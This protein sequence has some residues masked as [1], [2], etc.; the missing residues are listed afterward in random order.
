MHNFLF[1]KV[2]SFIPLV[3]FVIIFQNN[4]IC[5]AQPSPW[6]DLKNFKTV[7]NSIQ[8]KMFKSSQGQVSS[9]LGPDNIPYVNVGGM[10]EA[11][12]QNWNGNDSN[13]VNYKKESYFFDGQD[14][15][16]KVTIWLFNDTTG[17]FEKIWETEMEYSQKGKI[18]KI[19]DK[20]FFNGQWVMYSY[21]TV[22]YNTNDKP[23]SF[24]ET[25]WDST[26][27]R[28]NAEPSTTG[29]YTYDSTGKV[30]KLETE[31]KSNQTTY[32][33]LVLLS[34]FSDGRLNVETMHI[35]SKEFRIRHLYPDSNQEVT[36]TYTD[37]T[38]IFYNKAGM[39]DS[40]VSYDLLSDPLKLNK[41]VYTTYDIQ[42]RP[43]I[44][45]KSYWK[46]DSVREYGW[47]NNMRTVFYYSDSSAK[48]FMNHENQSNTMFLR[49]LPGKKIFIGNLPMTSVCTKIELFNTAGV[50]LYHYSIQTTEA[51][52][53]Q[54]ELDKY[55]PK[56]YYMFRIK[57][58]NQAKCFGLQLF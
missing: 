2:R 16:N 42:N 49:M 51:N 46:Y 48:S 30:I 28:W 17:T 9:F 35:L 6:S 3:L 54:I 25:E 47:T 39:V 18:V 13:W 50:K 27:N 44:E 19:I 56:G 1:E 55:L 37:S 34:Y 21:L 7:F 31:M 26:Q 10:K 41:R 20:K 43:L 36:V 15:L 45:L 14:N 38:F 40:T 4:S 57:Q 33:A 32:S 24:Y 58:E 23:Q 8:K 52:S 11:I 22:E 53:I 12:Y 29:I 5:I